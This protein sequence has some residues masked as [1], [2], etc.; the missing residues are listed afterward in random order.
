MEDLF[1]SVLTTHKLHFQQH[2]FHTLT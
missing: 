1:L 2:V